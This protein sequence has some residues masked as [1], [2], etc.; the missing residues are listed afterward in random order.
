MPLLYLLAPDNLLIGL[1]VNE[2]NGRHYRTGLIWRQ[3]ESEE[4]TS[5]DLEELAE[6]RLGPGVI[7]PTKQITA[8]WNQETMSIIVL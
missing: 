6:A 5:K 3:L 1:T 4:Y 7:A 2:T 8:I